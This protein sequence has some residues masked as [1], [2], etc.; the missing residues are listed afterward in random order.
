MIIGITGKA[1]SGKDT[2]ANYLIRNH[3]FNK[4]SV[5]APLKRLV[6]DIF[7]L[8]HDTVHDEI[9][10]EQPLRDWDG[11]TVRSLLQT[12]GMALRDDVIPGILSKSLVLRLK[13]N[14]DADW[15]IPDVRMP[16]EVESLKEE[17]G[18]DFVMIKVIRKGCDGATAGGLKNHRT[19]SHDLP[20]DFVLSNDRSIRDL[21]RK[22]K[23]VV[24]AV[25]EGVLIDKDTLNTIDRSI[26]NLKK[27]RVSK[28]MNIPKG[29]RKCGKCKK[30]S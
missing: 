3:G 10:R 13:K 27:G 28:P 17:F 18:G 6:Q 25:K 30:R 15:V 12:I 5:A 9:L 24:E 4:D 11:W 14:S 22:V 29:C 23:E 1:R 21:E 26:E 2:I 7:V 19:E 16:D 20:A 8:D